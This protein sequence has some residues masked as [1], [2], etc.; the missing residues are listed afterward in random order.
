MREAS[1]GVEVAVL[2]FLSPLTDAEAGQVSQLVTGVLGLV[3]NSSFF[4]KQSFVKTRVLHKPGMEDID[5]LH[6]SYN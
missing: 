1:V 6:M 4:F 3:S 5:I 2:E